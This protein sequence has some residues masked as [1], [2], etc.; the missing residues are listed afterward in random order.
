MEEGKKRREER[1]EVKTRREN[2]RHRISVVK[3]T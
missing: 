2:M 3:V 1:R